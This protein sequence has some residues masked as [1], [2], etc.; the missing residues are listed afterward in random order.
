MSNDALGH[1]AYQLQEQLTASEMREMAAHL[2]KMAEETEKLKPY[3]MEEIHAMIAEGERDLA[4]GRY[5]D[6][7][8]LF[9]EWN[10]EEDMM[11]AAEPEADYNVHP[12]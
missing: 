1:I 4:E 6:I 12:A 7:D 10:E 11:Y 3:T 5:R 8:D 9:R 2:I